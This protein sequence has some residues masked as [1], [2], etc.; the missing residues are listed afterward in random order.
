[1]PRWR[2]GG[3]VGTSGASRRCCVGRDGGRVGTRGASRRCH[4]GRAGGRVGTSGAS[5][6]CHVDRAGAGLV[7]AE[8]A[9]DASLVDGGWAPHG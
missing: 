6:I 7:P 5:R 9:E 1:M 2:A 3:R 4:V 8:P